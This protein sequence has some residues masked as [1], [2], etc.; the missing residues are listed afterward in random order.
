MSSRLD[1]AD[2]QSKNRKTKIMQ[3]SRVKKQTRKIVRRDRQDSR[4][5]SEERKDHQ[6]EHVGNR[7]PV[8]TKVGGVA[9]TEH[10]IH[11]SHEFDQRDE[12]EQQDHYREAGSVAGIDRLIQ[13]KTNEHSGTM[14]D[15]SPLVKVKAA[16]QKMSAEL[17][18]M[19]VRIGVLNHSV[20]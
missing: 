7:S 15:S 14:A 5:D 20:L 12:R 2:R 19:D 11:Q 3:N 18:T 13:N 10:P 8:Q 17:K 1:S 4:H 9:I 16:I 6:L